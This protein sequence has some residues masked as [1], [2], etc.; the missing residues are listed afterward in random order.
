MV[1]RRGDRSRVC[2][3]L[4]VGRLRQHFMLRLSNGVTV[5]IFKRTVMLSRA[6]VFNVQRRAGKSME[7]VLN[8]FDIRSLMT[9]I[10]ERLHN[11]NQKKI[12]IR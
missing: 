12:R 8:P 10:C 5:R 9:S 4:C 1:G 3:R 6:N 11:G 2:V 7:K